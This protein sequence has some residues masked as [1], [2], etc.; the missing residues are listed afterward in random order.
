MVYPPLGLFTVGLITSLL[1]IGLFGWALWKTEACKHWLRN[2]PRSPR[3]GAVLLT[4]AAGWTWLLIKTM[5]LGEFSTLRPILLIVVPV[6]YFL[7]LRYI[8]DF[9]SIRALGM[10]LLLGAEPMLE[11]AFLKPQTSRLLLVCLAYAMIIKGMFFVGM[12]YL[13][14]SWRDRVLRS[15]SVL[16]MALV[17]GLAYGVL[18]LLLALAFYR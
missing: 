5:D 7:S 18:L 10:L 17:G 4:L 9:L 13:F 3:A 2:F 16:R 14:L 15:P 11:A 1:L 12:P 6:A 8:E